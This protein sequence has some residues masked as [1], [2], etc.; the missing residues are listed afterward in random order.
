M[1][2]R[3]TAL[4]R[5]GVLRRL[6][7]GGRCLSGA[8]GVGGGG[9][10]GV[11]ENVRGDPRKFMAMFE[12]GRL[13]VDKRNVSA[14]MES[15][16]RVEDAAVLTLYEDYLRR[17]AA[18]ESGWIVSSQ[19]MRSAVVGNL[20]RLVG[21][22]LLAIAAVSALG[23][24][25]DVQSLPS[26]AVRG[27]G[28]GRVASTSDKRFDDVKGCKEAKE[29]LIE[30]VEFLKNPE[31][32]TRLGGKLPKG[33]LLS[34]PPGTGKTLL[35]KAIAGEAGV[36]FFYC[37]GSE[38]E[39]MYV[40]VGAKRIRELFAAAKKQYPCIIFIDEIDAVGAT[41]KLKEQQSLRMTLNQ[42]LVELDG[43]VSTEGIIVIGAT[44]FPEVL[45]QALV[46]PGRFDRNIVVPLPDVQGRKEILEFYM[47]QVNIA[48][49]VDPMTLARGTPGCS[50][51]DLFNIINIAAV[52]AAVRGLDTVP[53]ELMEFAKDRVLM[54]AER[55]SAVI[56][57]SE[58]RATA[59]HE[60]GHA[61]V[62]LF[63]EAADPIH[64]ATIIPRGRAL[65]MVHQLPDTDQ[66]SISRK[67]LLADL[68]VSMGGRVAEELVFGKENV[69]TGASSDITGATDIARK[70]V[71]VW[72]MSSAVGPVDVGSLDSAM[73]GPSTQEIIEK[74]VEMLLK[75]SYDRATALLTE[76]RKDLDILAEALIRYETLTGDE[77][78]N[79]IFKGIHPKDSHAT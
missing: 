61:L 72:G 13:E 16:G 35:A 40:G 45:D 43:F 75:D 23:S 25:L 58:R 11:V 1:M 17:H 9:G 21:S 4:R 49:D 28:A 27:A 5:V 73:L 42:L 24:F 10:E 31:K 59:Y 64:K 22:V 76:H 37:S 66:V 32:F 2:E 77:I 50:G 56:P 29:E 68:D 20:G 19:E 53:M 65:G 18:V 60:G 48:G 69:S 62:A 63:N 7:R 34:G 15:V 71:T 38:F 12:Q 67:R 51:A 55:K 39:E 79:L 78:R 14:Y 44:N 70:M 54:G 36:P 26:A 74:E 6:V 46:R 52:E 57:E 41:R 3:V 47:S 33:V 8:G 30:I